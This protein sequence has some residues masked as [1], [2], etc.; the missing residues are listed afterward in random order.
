MAEMGDT[1]KKESSR[2]SKFKSKMGR[3]KKKT[4]VSEQED[5]FS[6]YK[7]AFDQTNTII[8]DGNEA[9]KQLVPLK[10]ALKE[11]QDRSE[12]RERISVFKQ[13]VDAV[14]ADYWG[15]AK[16]AIK[17]TYDALNKFR[18]S[19]PTDGG[20]WL[21]NLL[22][23]HETLNAGRKDTEALSRLSTADFYELPFL[24]KDD[25]MEDMASMVIEFKLEMD[26]AF[27][28]YINF[29][30]IIGEINEASESLVEFKVMPKLFKGLKKDN[31]AEFLGKKKSLEVAFQNLIARLQDANDIIAAYEEAVKGFDGNVAKLLGLQFEEDREA[32][33]VLN[34]DLYERYSELYVDYAH[35]KPKELL[36]RAG[37]K[38]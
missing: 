3:G 4:Q 9:S 15:E 18:K 23:L 13:A 12:F 11:S 21:D 19:G 32:L 36:E 22:K 37:L 29:H 17:E 2:W 20:K 34:N 24:K 16:T 38:D 25:L 1:P 33:S 8:N 35:P 14:K 28:A 5:L 30:W 10:A 7:R 31:L 26:P 6:A 27:Q